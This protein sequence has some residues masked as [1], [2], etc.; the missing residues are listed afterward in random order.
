M[1][2]IQ[3]RSG[4]DVSSFSD[5]KSEKEILFGPGTRFRVTAVDVDSGTGRKIIHMMEL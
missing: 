5:Y 3:S 4:R 1:M 2:V